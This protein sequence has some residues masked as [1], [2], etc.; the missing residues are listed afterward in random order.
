MSR[1]DGAGLA[2]APSQMFS[3]ENILSGFGGEPDK[4]LDNALYLDMRAKM[5][6]FPGS[7]EPSLAETGTCLKTP[8]LE[9][10]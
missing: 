4:L 5:L 7:E 9:R 6:N 2:L 1:L 10:P 8:A 3:R